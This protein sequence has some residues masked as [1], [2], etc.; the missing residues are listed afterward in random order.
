MLWPWFRQLRQGQAHVPLCTTKT[1]LFCSLHLAQKRLLLER[2]REKLGDLFIFILTSKTIFSMVSLSKIRREKMLLFSWGVHPGVTRVVVIVPTSK[3]HSA[4]DVSPDAGN[5]QFKKYI[6]FHSSSHHCKCRAA[7][8]DKGSILR[9][10]SPPNST[11][12]WPKNCL[13]FSFK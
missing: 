2:K 3:I 6:S 11:T 13:F 4:T 5:S 1:S 9:L 8:I 7:T 10:G 12:N